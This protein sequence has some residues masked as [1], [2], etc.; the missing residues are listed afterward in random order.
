MR[1]TP[2]YNRQLFKSVELLQTINEFAAKQKPGELDFSATS[3]L[4]DLLTQHK[5]A[6]LKHLLDEVQWTNKKQANAYPFMDD[7][8][9]KLDAD[10][11]IMQPVHVPY[12]MTYSFL[13]RA[14]ETTATM[15]DKPDKALHTELTVWTSKHARLVF[16][17][18]I[19]SQIE[20]K[21]K[22]EWLEEEIVRRDK[23]LTE[24]AKKARK[25]QNRKR[26]GAEGAGEPDSDIDDELGKAKPKR[27]EPKSPP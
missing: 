20:R 12:M 6:I 1:L 10:D 2:L 14:S 18:R 21:D 27:L 13:S 24:E 4:I 3:D 26:A 16:H 8:Y 5:E 9:Q 7:P 15:K 19:K 23:C 22:P 17:S 11:Q 25:A